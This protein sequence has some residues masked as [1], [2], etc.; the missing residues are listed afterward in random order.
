[1]TRTDV[2]APSEDIV[3]G[4]GLFKDIL[5]R[6]R[7]LNALA[8][9]G[10]QLASR[11]F[12]A[13]LTAEPEY[14]RL[15]EIWVSAYCGETVGTRELS[16]ALCRDL[17]HLPTLKALSLVGLSGWMPANLLNMNATDYLPPR[18]LRL[19]SI[20]INGIS[21][22]IEIRLLFQALADGLR[23]VQLE[24]EIAWASIMEDLALIPPSVE[25][26]KLSL[27][28]GACENNSSKYSKMAHKRFLMA[29][30]NPGRLI[31]ATSLP[32]ALRD[33]S[34]QGDLVGPETFDVLL[35]LPSLD[36]LAL[37]SHTRFSSSDL[38]AF[39]ESSPSLKG[40][41]VNVCQ[42][43]VARGGIT[44]G[45]ASAR[46]NKRTPDSPKPVWR[47]GFRLDDAQAVFLACQEKKIGIGG[48]IVCASKLLPRGVEGHDCRGWCG[49]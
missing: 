15:S 27:G 49:S 34:L 17:S 16:P 5:L 6:L 38:I 28:L 12:S 9:N 22:K 11:L 19:K 26:L 14:P 33:L 8:V 4:V 43:A 3:I 13:E 2:H 32:A 23:Y 48:T 21:L 30:L 1:M 20:C 41:I 45:G 10:G 31:S 44:G 37:G 39:I 29:E 42:C 25:H 36:T 46:R 18:S 7:N 40:L 24:S 35:A 47:D